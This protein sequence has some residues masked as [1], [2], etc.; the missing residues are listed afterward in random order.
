MRTAIVLALIVS[1]TI[2]ACSPKEPEIIRPKEAIML[3]ADIAPG[4]LA[5]VFE[6]RVK[7]TG[8]DGDYIFLNS[9]SDYRDQ[10]SLNVAVHPRA[11]E[12]FA[13]ANNGLSPDV[14]LAGKLIRVSGEARRVKIVFLC[15]GKQTEKYYYQ[16]QVFVLDMDQIEIV[17]Q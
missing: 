15:S 12:E 6:M 5:G 9:E 17:G 8:R 7:G 16:T 2:T 1:V 13:L 11:T 3:A 4:G 14:S 10:R